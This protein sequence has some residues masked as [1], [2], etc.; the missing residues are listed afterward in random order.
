[1]R[2]ETWR[3]PRSSTLLRGLIVAVATW[4]VLILWPLMAT[5]SPQRIRKHPVPVPAAF[6]ANLLGLLGNFSKLARWHD[7]EYWMCAGTLLGAVRD[8]GLI[9]WDDDGDLCA[10]SATIEKLFNDS[11]VRAS[12]RRLGVR[13]GSDSDDRPAG[14]IR[15]GI[16]DDIHRVNFVNGPGVYLDLFEMEQVQQPLLMGLLQRTVIQYRHER[17]RRRW[18][19]EWFILHELYPLRNYTFGETLRLLGPADP[20]PYL[21]RAFGSWLWGQLPEFIPTGM[22]GVQ[23]G[24][25]WRKHFFTYQHHVFS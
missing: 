3:R 15:I 11:L 9:P 4:A 6:K 14:G 12:M 20:V 19:W 2:K 22:S 17:N 5:K 24:R 13:R 23:F 7:L 10:P 21:D 8:G 1:M 25:T 18:P 16:A